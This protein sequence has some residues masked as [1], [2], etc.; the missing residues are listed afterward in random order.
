MQVSKQY[1]LTGMGSFFFSFCCLFS[2][3]ILSLISYPNHISVKKKVRTH[4]AIRGADLV[5]ATEVIASWLLGCLKR[6]RADVAT[7]VEYIV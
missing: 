2:F 3:I 5:F 6:S 1:I 7:F 4:Q